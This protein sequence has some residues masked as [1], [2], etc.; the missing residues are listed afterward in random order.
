MSADIDGYFQNKLK[1]LWQD[2]F[3]D[4]I[5]ARGYVMDVELKYSVKFIISGMFEI[6]CEALKNEDIE[7]GSLSKVMEISVELDESFLKRK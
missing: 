3:L 1:K 6:V 5:K 2:V 4:A 7:Y